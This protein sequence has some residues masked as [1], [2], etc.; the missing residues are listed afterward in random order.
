MRG[1]T[2]LCAGGSLAVLAAAGQGPRP[3]APSAAADPQVERGAR[4]PWAAELDPPLADAGPPSG[5]E[6][7]GLRASPN[8]VMPDPAEGTAGSR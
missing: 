3:S 4:P 8:G 1:W 6:T 5:V 2:F 7:Q